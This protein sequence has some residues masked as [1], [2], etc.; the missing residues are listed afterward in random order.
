MPQVVECQ[1]HVSHAS[2]ENLSIMLRLFSEAAITA[3]IKNDQE[4]L[5]M[6]C[7]IS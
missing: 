3:P 4:A 5:R 6:S 7:L 1:G 2:H